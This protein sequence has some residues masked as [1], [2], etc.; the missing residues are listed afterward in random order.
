MA[1]DTQERIVSFANEL[2]TKRSMLNLR[3]ENY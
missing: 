2:V 3:N 1:I